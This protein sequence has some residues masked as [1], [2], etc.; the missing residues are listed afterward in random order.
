MSWKFVKT[1]F[2]R[3][4]GKVH[5]TQKIG[6]LLEA[7]NSQDAAQQVKVFLLYSF[8]FSVV[9]SLLIYLHGMGCWLIKR[10]EN[11]V[12]SFNMFISKKKLK[13]WNFLQQNE[14]KVHDFDVRI[15]CIL[16]LNIRD[17]IKLY[18]PKFYIQIKC[19]K[20]ISN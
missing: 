19:C 4:K 14:V 1:K 5:F 8:P 2:W 9:V 7:H 16:R 17:F 15:V 13:L 12:W 3:D 11:L 6:V 18:N 20:W 10:G